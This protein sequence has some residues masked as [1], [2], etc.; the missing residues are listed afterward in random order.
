MNV[1]TEAEL[2]QPARRTV[3]P[4][5]VALA[6]PD[7]GMERQARIGTTRMAFVIAFTCAVIAAFAQAY[8]VDGKSATLQKLE[9]QGQLLTM[10]DRQL[11]DA[12]TED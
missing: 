5:L 11:E 2:Q 1:S 4:A 9:K 3:P 7:V 10:S 8:R 12:V 6:A